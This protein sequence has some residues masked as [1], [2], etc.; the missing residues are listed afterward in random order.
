[1]TENKFQFTPV[2][3]IGAGRSGT[4]ALR[5]MLIRLPQFATW[6]CDEINPIWRHGN[7]FWPDDEIPP[8]R[9]TPSI[10]EFIRRAFDQ[11][12]RKSGR[13][14]FVVEK[15]CANSLRVPFVEKVLPEAKYIYLVRNGVDV[16]ASAQK[17]WQGKLELPGI[18]YF[19]AKVRYTPLID[20]PVYGIAFLRSR[21][22]FLLN[23]KRLSIWGPRFQGMHALQKLPLVELCAR[24]WVACMNRADEA[25]VEILEERVI[26][27]Y[28]E[29]FTLNPESTLRSILAF[30]RAD[31]NENEIS[32]AVSLV[33]Q[34]SIGKGR[35]ETADLPSQIVE[36]MEHP[37]ARHGYWE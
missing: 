35:A 30:L 14:L 19:A 18:P 5:D 4:N 24:Q 37:L 28:Y 32:T 36:I 17:R 22:G 27:V 31:A 11:I 34:T 12:W 3:I 21:I 15:T 2:V 9:A 13:P 6:G 16:L 23:L 29:D 7:I 33:R 1:M 10:R 8:E 25:F 20:L 26:I